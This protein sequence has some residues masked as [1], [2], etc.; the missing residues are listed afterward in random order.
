MEGEKKAGVQ[1]VDLDAPLQL[2]AAGTSLV[3]GQNPGVDLLAGLTAHL[4]ASHETNAAH[5]AAWRWQASEVMVWSEGNRRD[6]HHHH[7]Q[8]G[9]VAG[10]PLWF[11]VVRAE[12][13]A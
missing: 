13:N 12:W 10:V 5:C 9:H 6:C 11:V 7:H 8:N 4:V 2:R 1:V 3:R